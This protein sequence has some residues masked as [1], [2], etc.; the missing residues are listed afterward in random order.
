MPYT[1]GE[2]LWKDVYIKLD[3]GAILTWVRHNKN[4]FFSS[5][6]DFENAIQYYG[7][8][9]AG[10]GYLVSRNKIDYTELGMIISSPKEYLALRNS[11]FHHIQFAY[12][13]LLFF[14]N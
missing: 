1:Y 7:A 12:H 4:S 10:L 2:L 9:E 14:G 6:K 11:N 3:S 5:F 13:M 8:I